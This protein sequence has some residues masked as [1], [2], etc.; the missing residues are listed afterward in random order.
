MRRLTSDGKLETIK[1]KTITPMGTGKKATQEQINATKA[2]NDFLRKMCETPILKDI[3]YTWKITVPANQCTSKY[4]YIAI[5]G[6]HEKLTTM[7]LKSFLRPIV[8]NNKVMFHHCYESAKSALEQ[9]FDDISIFQ[10]L[11][12]E[13]MLSLMDDNRI[14]WFTASVP[15]DTDNNTIYGIQWGTHITIDKQDVEHIKSDILYLWAVIQ[16][17]FQ[18][19][20]Q[21]QSQHGEI[22][23]A[24]RFVADTGYSYDDTNDISE[25]TMTDVLV[26]RINSTNM[27]VYLTNERMLEN[28]NISSIMKAMK[29][30]LTAKSYHRML[31]IIDGKIA[32]LTNEEISK[33]YNLTVNEVRNTISLFRTKYDLLKVIHSYKTGKITYKQA[34]ADSGLKEKTFDRICKDIPIIDIIPTANTGTDGFYGVIHESDIYGFV[35]AKPSIKV[36]KRFNVISTVYNTQDIKTESRIINGKKETRQTMGYKVETI[37]K[38]ASYPV[39][40]GCFERGNK[41]NDENVSVNA[42]LKKWI[43]DTKNALIISKF[44]RYPLKHSNGT[45]YTSAECKKYYLDNSSYFENII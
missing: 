45:R 23:I 6:I 3:D 25:E 1:E 28:T 27:S 15:F 22:L 29:Y 31:S 43:M 2:H 24:D 19:N 26:S 33:R 17:Y 5:N 40:C 44:G 8:R 18:R 39:D 7:I 37:G 36:E 16:K 38:N 21:I 41:S 42:N 13:I 30:L 20:R 14:K 35:P 34:I 11:T 4:E 32:G 10:D 12:Q 9:R